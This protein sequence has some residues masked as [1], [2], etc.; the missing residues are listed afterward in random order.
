MQEIKDGYRASLR[1]NKKNPEHMEIYEMF[2]SIASSGRYVNESQIFREGI[3]NL[4]EKDFLDNEIVAKNLDCMEC[5]EIISQKV[6]KVMEE[7]LQG[8]LVSSITDTTDAG[9]CKIKE[10]QGAAAPEE[11]IEIPTGLMDFMDSMG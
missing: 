11:T 8:K 6:Q 3:R 2:Q 5:A 1:L 9:T 10:N 7:L 4:Y